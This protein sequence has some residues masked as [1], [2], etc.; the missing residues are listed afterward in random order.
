MT[1]LEEKERDKVLCKKLHGK[2]QHLC[3][4]LK[5]HRGRCSKNR[6][7]SNILSGSK[8]IAE[9][10]TLD[11]YSTPGDQKAV[12]NRAD[13]C[14]PRQLS[15]DEVREQNKAGRRAVGIRSKFSSTPQDCFEIHKQLT[16]QALAIPS[17]LEKV[18]LLNND[19]LAIIE[20]LNPL[21]Q[22]YKNNS[23]KALSCRVCGEPIKEEDFNTA[24][25]CHNSNSAQLGH[26]E[27]PPDKDSTAHRSRNVQWIHRDCNIIQ[28]EKTEQETLEKLEKIVTHLRNQGENNEG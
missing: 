24:H 23:N 12:K 6:L 1:E 4:R 17:V 18:D 22:G 21:I 2:Y 26:I 7:S 5:D 11:T 14:Y 8:K 9:K 16:A 13:R 3:T 10:T 20:H 27:P 28:G 25:G 19:N 15:Q